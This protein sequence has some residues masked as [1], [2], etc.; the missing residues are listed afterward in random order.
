MAREGIS[1]YDEIKKCQVLDKYNL[2]DT[3]VPSVLVKGG[4]I[5]FNMNAIRLLNETPF[6]EILINPDEKYML[7]VPCGQYDVFAIDWC[8]TVKKT[9]KI[10]PKEMRSKF[11][12]PKLYTLMGWDTDLSYKVQCFFQAFGK[13]KELLYFDL[14]DYVTMVT[15]TVQTADGKERKRSRPYYLTDWQDSFGPPLKDIAEKVNRDFTGF[16][17]ANPNKENENDQLALF[18][19]HSET[20]GGS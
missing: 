8:K 3:K 9:G 2:T 7:V 4:Y 18:E 13:G 12:S 5:R 19:H 14:T 17:V 10:A 15:T 6:I 11:L 1:S 16:Y 20:E